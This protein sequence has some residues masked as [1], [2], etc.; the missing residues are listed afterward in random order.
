MDHPGLVEISL[1]GD[2]GAFDYFISGQVLEGKNASTEIGDIQVAS[3]IDAGEF[4]KLYEYWL[5]YE[6]ASLDGVMTVGQMDLNNKF[7][8]ADNAS[9]FLNSSMGIS[10]T[11]FTVPTYPEPAL[12]L[13][14][15]QHLGANY[16]LAGTVS[17]GAGNDDFS[18]L[19][20]ML[21]WRYHSDTIGLKAGGWHHT[22]ELTALDGHIEDSSEGWYAV[23]EGQLTSMPVGYYAQYG[24]TDKRLTEITQHVGAGITARH[25]LLNHNAVTG[26]GVTAARLSELTDTQRRWETVAEVFVKFQINDALSL[27]PDIQYVMSPAGDDRNVWVSTLRVALSF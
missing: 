9:E 25:F 11:I 27:K 6:F 14:Y 4:S 20:Y 5:S 12:S 24:Y 19:F 3:N 8:Y 16:S 15:E 23:L 2:I 21:E 10:P 7:A 18:D 22:G 17:A 26:V 13:V 1:V